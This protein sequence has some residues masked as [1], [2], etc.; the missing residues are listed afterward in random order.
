MSGK[1]L[2]RRAYWRGLLAWIHRFG[3][4][5]A[6]GGVAMVL[7]GS[8]RACSSRRVAKSRGQWVWSVFGGS[9]GHGSAAMQAQ[10]EAR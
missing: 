5:I 10:I 7:E 6:V 8:G 3:A 2:A 9:F 4:V 1:H